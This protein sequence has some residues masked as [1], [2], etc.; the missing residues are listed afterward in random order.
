MSS[1]T[2]E[3]F[4]NMN[5]VL[6]FYGVGISFST[7]Q[8]TTKTQN[9]YSKRIWESRRKGKIFLIILAICTL[10]LLT[11]GFIGYFAADIS[12]L[13][14]LSLGLIVFGVGFIGLLKTAVEMYEHHR[15]D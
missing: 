10:L 9:D 7:L 12:S 6:I 2:D 3:F 1:Y 8:D 4:L 15:K 11:S 13:E 5:S 14:E